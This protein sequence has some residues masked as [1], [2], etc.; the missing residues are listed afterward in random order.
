M[1]TLNRPDTAGTYEGV[2]SEAKLILRVD[3]AESGLDVISGDLFFGDQVAGFEFHHSFQTTALVVVEEDDADVVQGP[4]K[5]HRADMLDIARI[6]LRVPVE[7]DPLATYTFYRLT[8]FGR[9]TAATLSFPLK[10]TSNFF[11]QV[12]LEIDRIEGVPTLEAY[13]PCSSPDTP[14][15]VDCRALTLQSSFRDAGLDLLVDASGA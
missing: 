15:N 6:D 5:V 11:R 14:S 8:S 12:E 4:V 9:Q 10:K 13:D 2:Q 7:G 3:V 1:A